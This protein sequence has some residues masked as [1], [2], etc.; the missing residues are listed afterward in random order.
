MQG[1]TGLDVRRP[2]IVPLV[3][4]TVSQDIVGLRIREIQAARQDGPEKTANVR[5][6][7]KL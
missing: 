5:I 6:E 1:S 3:S 7:I 4:V 2:A